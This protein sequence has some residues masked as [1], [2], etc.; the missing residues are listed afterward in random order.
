MTTLNIDATERTSTRPLGVADINAWKAVFAGNVGALDEAM[1]QGANPNSVHPIAQ[2][3]LLEQAAKQMVKSCELCVVL[4]DRGAQ[5]PDTQ[6][7]LAFE[8]AWKAIADDS[9]MLAKKLMDEGPQWSDY[10]LDEKSKFMT[11]EP[12]KLDMLLNARAAFD[13]IAQ[14]NMTYGPA[15]QAARASSSSSMRASP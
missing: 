5:V 10:F 4:I 9:V 8:L 12:T 2:H 3:N 6:A 14:F 7:P 13:A 1:V 15:A 11:S